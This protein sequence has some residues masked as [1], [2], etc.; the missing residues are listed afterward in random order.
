MRKLLNLQR[1]RPGQD[2]QMGFEGLKQ[3]GMKK[4]SISNT[5]QIN[6]AIPFVKKHWV[7]IVAFITLICLVHTVWYYTVYYPLDE[8]AAD[9]AKGSAKTRSKGELY[10]W[11]YNTGF[12]IMR[13][14]RTKSLIFSLLGVSVL[15]SEFNYQYLFKV[16]FVEEG[17]KGKFFY[18]LVLIFF[19]IFILLA[20]K[21]LL[22]EKMQPFGLNFFLTNFWMMFAFVY[23][24]ARY[25]SESHRRLKELVYQ[26]T[27]AEL[28]ALK[29]QINPHFLFNVLNNLYGS[30]IVEDSPKTAA[31]I[32]QLSRIMRHV[33][34]ETKTERSP[35]EKELTF[36]RDY[37][38]LQKMRIPE[39]PNIS[40]K[41]DIYWDE[42][43]A[44]IAPLLVIPYVENAFKYGISINQES[45]IEIDLKVENNKLS[46][47]CRNSI[48]RHVDKLE[49]GTSTGLEN[50]R[51][52][53]ELYYPGRH[54]LSVE[55]S[56]G[57]FEVKLQV[58]LT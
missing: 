45:F 34:E 29:A 21:G 57:V 43:P 18:A 37:I 20:M 30:A 8:L 50:T 58:R 13:F 35:I 48:I 55:A 16:L 14:F 6:Q 3:T 27:K 32:E 47:I 53:L 1:L 10:L 9:Y 26:K 49:V 41:T 36:L 24:A 4:L 40:I 38:Q 54:Q 42:I 39:R 17:R 28:V 52:R 11:G 23:A 46:F 22:G 7:S 5:L 56:E 25:T 12:W 31:G 19:Y 2:L 51:R 44:K 15:F 33:V